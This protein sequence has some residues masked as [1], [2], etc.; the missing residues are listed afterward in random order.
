MLFHFTLISISE[1]L[2]SLIAYQIPCAVL[3]W[4]PLLSQCVIFFY[5]I[6]CCM[7]PC[8][9]F[10]VFMCQ[11]FLHIYQCCSIRLSFF[12]L[13]ITSWIYMPPAIL[14][15]SKYNEID[16]TQLFLSYIV[17]FC[18]WFSF[19]IAMLMLCPAYVYLALC[20]MQCLLWF[21]YS[22]VRIR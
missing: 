7:V 10:G 21:T 5:G 8:V 20:P 1:T 9:Y 22:Y 6:E 3:A 4:H 18:I 13:I 16:L 19:I 17:L 12:L 2:K 11:P 14:V 15:L